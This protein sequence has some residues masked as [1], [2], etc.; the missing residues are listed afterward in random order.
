MSRNRAFGAGLSKNENCRALQRI[1]APCNGEACARGFGV[2][3]DADDHASESPPVRSA[4][5]GCPIARRLPADNV[6][7]SAGQ[8]LQRRTIAHPPQHQGAHATARHQEEAARA[9]KAQTT[10]PAQEVT[11]GK[12]RLVRHGTAAARGGDGS[13]PRLACRASKSNAVASR[14]RPWEASSDQLNG[15]RSQGLR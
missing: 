9:R 13:S 6:I 12:G 3:T 5:P 2:L 11:L 10:R 4:C 14:P 8:R 7:G 15:G 1:A